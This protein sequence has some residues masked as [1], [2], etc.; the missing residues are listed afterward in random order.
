[1]KTRNFGRFKMNSELEPK[2]V[3]EPDHEPEPSPEP[4]PE[5]EPEPS[6]ESEP[7][8]ETVFDPE[9]E[10][11]SEGYFQILKTSKYNCVFVESLKTL[12]N[13]ICYT[14]LR[15]LYLI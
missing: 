11:E 7:E 12:K 15:E 5:P 14:F 10:T 9:H 13:V 8:S 6:L 4:E 3:H 1:M 2:P